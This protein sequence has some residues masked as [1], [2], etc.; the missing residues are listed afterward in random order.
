MTGRASKRSVARGRLSLRALAR[1]LGVSLAAVQ[2]AI[3]T[4]RLQQSIGR[5]DGKPFVQD[6]ALA[7]KEWTEGRTK[8][9]PPP[10]QAPEQLEL[11]PTAGSL[12][13]A[14]LRVALQREVQLRIRN[15]QDR[16]Q[17]IVAETARRE[18]FECARAVRDAVL[19][20]PARLS[21]ELAATSDANLVHR[22]LDD[23]LRKALEAAAEVLA[24]GE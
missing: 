23:E 19:N 12:T 21:A 3:K 7:K 10:P 22:R 11:D 1:Q 17:L 8:A 4:G 6:V 5:A 24:R 20:V 13:E 14:Q 9:P 15:R 2:K 18:A 16:G